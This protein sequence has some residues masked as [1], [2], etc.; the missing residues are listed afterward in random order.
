MEGLVNL[1]KELQNVIHRGLTNLKKSPKERLSVDYIQTRR[2]LLERDWNLFVTNYTK[3]HEQYETQ[4]IKMLSE[5]YDSTEDTYITYTCL[6]KSMLAKYDVPKATIPEPGTSS[7]SNKSSTN[8][9][10]KLP[11]ISIPNFSGKYSEWTTFRDLFVSLVHN[12]SSLDN[13]Q[14]MHYLKSHLSGEA[15][16]L[17][18]QTPVSEANYSQC[19]AQLEKR[20]SNKKYLVNCILKRLFGL[21]RMHVESAISLKELLDTTNDCLNGLK[22]L[23]V[24]VT[25]WDVIIIHIVTF[26]LDSETRKQ[27]ELSLSNHDSN[28]LPTYDEFAMFLEN[29]FRA[30]EFIEPKRNLQTQ[31]NHSHVAKSMVVSSSSI[32]CEYCNESHKLCFCKRFAKEPLEER[33]NFVAQHNICFNCLGGNHT[34]INCKKPTT[35]KLCHKRHHS[36][37]HPNLDGT[38]KRD[39][40]SKPTVV[41][42][43]PSTSSAPVVSCISTNTVPVP[44]QV[45]LATAL[46]KAES[47]TG[48]YQVVRALLDQGSQACFVT[49]DTVQFLRLKKIPIHGM[50]SG[51]GQK[52]TIAKYMVN[53]TIQSRVDSGFKLNFNAYVISKITSYLPDQALNKNTFNWLDITNLQLAD[54]QF[55]QPSKIDILLGADV[56]GCI[57]KTGIIKSPTATLIAQNTTL[58]WILSGVVHRSNINNSSSYTQP[59]VSVAHAQFNLDQI[60]K[61]FW[62][63]QDQTS[64][65]KVLSPE[66]QQCEDFYK[67]TT[68]RRAD[69]RYEVRLPFRVKDP[70]CTAGDSRAIAENRLK[71]LEKRLAKNTEL[72]E[73]YTDVIEEYLRLGHLRPVKQDDSKKEIAVYLPHHAVVREDKTTTKVRVVFNASQKNNRGVSLNDTLMVGPTLQAELRH[74]IMRWR[75]HSIGLVG[76]IIK[77][78]RQIRVADEDAMFQRILWR[79]SPNESIKDYEL[80]TV[81]FGTASAPYLAVRTLHQIAYDEGDE[82][83]L[84]SEKVLSCY[85][86]DDLLT[87][88]DDVTTGIQIYKQMKEL[89]AKGGFELQKWS[90]NNKELLDQINTIEYKVESNEENES[91]AKDRDQKELEMKLDNTMK[92]L[93][94]TWDRNDDSFR[95]TVHL[96]PLQNTPATKRTVISDIARLFD[97]LGWLAPTIVVAKIFIQKLWLAGLGWDEPL[98]KN[99][100]EEWRTYREELTL[101]TEVHIPRWLGKTIETDVELHGFCDASKVAYSAVVYMRLTKDVGE[102]KVSLLAAKTRVAPIKQVSIPRLELCGAVLLSQLLMETAEVLNIPKDKVKAWTDSTVVL[103]WINSHPSKWKTFVANR[104]SEILTTMTASQ[105]FHVSTK[106]NPADVASRGLSPGLFTQNTMWFSGP[107]FLKEKEIIYIRPKDLEINLE[108]SIKTHVGVIISDDFD[109]LERFSSLSKLLRVVAYCRRFLN[110]DTRS[111]HYLQKKEIH[112][113][114]ECCIKIVQKK[115]F[116]T[117]YKQLYDKSDLP[118]KNSTLK[119]LCPYLD[120][121]GIMKVQGRIDKAPL[122]E[123]IK[124]PIILPKK[125]HF[126]LLLIADAHSR[127]LHGG[128][129]LMINYL[130]TAY[131]IIGVRELVK[132]YVRKC[133]ICAK[134]RAT[135]R[136]QMM[137]SLPSIRCSPARPFLHS[138]VDYAG[139]INIRTTKGRGHKSYKGYICLFVCMSTRALHLEVVSDMTTQAFLAAFRRFVSRRG[140]CSKLWSDN[141]TTFVGA[142]REL[143]QIS[144]LQ[145]SIAENLEANGTEWHF[146]PPHAPNFGG[147]WEAGVKSTKYHIKRVIGESTLTYEELSTFL[148]QVEA[149]LN[150]R[151]ISVIH[152]DDPGESMPLTPGHFLIGEPFVSV[153][154][155]NYENVSVGSLTRWQFVQRMLQSFWKRW[156]SEYLTNLMNRYKWSFIV[157]EPNVGDVVLIKEDDLPPSRWMLGRV[158]EKHPGDDKVTRVVTLKTKTS[159]IK[160][161]TNKLCIL[162]VADK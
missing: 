64:T 47:K 23:K 17:V 10:V 88:C 67:A 132:L 81:T 114:L 46:V 15:E 151:P 45:L 76:D 83:P 150:S 128:P 48:N 119:S 154:D 115:E 156:S 113:A 123:L 42:A 98:T 90:T 43:S 50:V 60:L 84:V 137:G 85:Y 30:L 157:P 117:E 73:K 94:L 11:K 51:L 31:N 89:L 152:L 37:L 53:I 149:C 19:W 110:R 153:P 38:N 44:G 70:Q 143:Q 54:P 133:I 120:D 4:G 140:H 77:M 130:R 18:R 105:W 103:A 41:E 5:L 66:E 69:G 118:L 71:S 112:E 99:L 146:I 122:D 34:V 1:L 102:V 6:I 61:Q 134:Q 161:P 93:G 86:M 59:C 145:S 36:L 92:I 80:V 55:N 124:H 91:K 141:G 87:G 27:W 39:T 63:I 126:T 75:T 101:L 74:T 160:R 158:V 22:N 109:L 125:S 144:T 65:K 26:K 13:V 21:K 135:I 33:R 108:Q 2:E 3:L 12:N 29:R 107:Q 58:G 32:R 68:K 57:I 96:P 97:P 9:F 25:T 129:Q 162:P 82:Y 159:I 147:L 106:D 104:T 8:S 111:K 52:S 121:K 35:C 155:Y 24:D 95:Y 131:W 79:S 127:T 49:E 139:P 40:A 138:G 56:Y 136:N 14:K 62:E 148:T 28:E 20:Y 7:N 16:Q 100:T 72:K 116:S 78:Y 142:S